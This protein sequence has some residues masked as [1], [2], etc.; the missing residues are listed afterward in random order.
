MADSSFSCDCVVHRGK[1]WKK[2]VKFIQKM[3][4]ENPTVSFII[5]TA[6]CKP[7]VNTD[8]TFSIGNFM[9]KVRFLFIMLTVL[10]STQVV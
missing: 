9:Y 2:R 3:T 1:E 7:I 8:K 10:Q 4:G 6:I 5:C